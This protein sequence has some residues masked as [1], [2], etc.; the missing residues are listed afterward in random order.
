[1]VDSALVRGY[2]KASHTSS[3]VPGI[4]RALAGFSVITLSTSSEKPGTLI[5]SPFFI[6]CNKF[7]T[8]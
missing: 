3:I 8:I 4:E 7:K 1:M 2:E 6:S 5:Y